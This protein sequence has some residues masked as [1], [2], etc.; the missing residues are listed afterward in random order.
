MNEINI[1]DRNSIDIETIFENTL[2]DPELLSTIDID[3]LLKTIEDNKNDYLENK[4][5]KKV[6]DDIFNIINTLNTTDEKKTLLCNKLS[7]YRHV[8]EIR[9]LHKGKY[10]RWI[11][12]K[13]QNENPLLT[14]GGTLV[15]II[16]TDGGTN[17]TCKTTMNR[18]F[19][20]KFDECLV[21]QKLSMEEQLILM[22]YEYID[23][24]TNK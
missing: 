24:N 19:Q 17:I 3:Q 11:R 4:T 10:T 8:D 22:A 12:K 14:N 6:T 2:K 5:I 23:K 7:G 1:Q 9:E 20:Y 21:F 13:F 18:F 16:F 15:N